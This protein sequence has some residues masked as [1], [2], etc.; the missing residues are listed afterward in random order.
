MK[1]KQI[2]LTGIL[3]IALGGLIL[4][5]CK[6]DSTA[7][8]SDWTAAQD[9]ANATSTSNDAQT[10]AN[11]AVQS[12]GHSP[13]NFSTYYNATVTWARDTGAGD[14]IYIVF[15]S[16]PTICGDYKYRE[17]EIIVYWP[18]GSANNVWAAYS[19]SAVNVTEEFRGYAV[20]TASNNMNTISGTRTWTN[21]GQNQG[22]YENWNFNANLT[23]TYSNGQKATWSSIRNNV[24]TKVG[25]TWYYAVSGNAT[26]TSRNGVIYTLNIA[27]PLYIT[28]APWWAGGCAWIE[29][30]TLNINRQ[31]NNNTLSVNFGNVG[32]CDAT[33]VATINGNNYTFSMW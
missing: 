22:G 33:A 29:S 12:A 13:I 4:T 15:P 3:G 11:T 31:G 23:L 6:K 21:E 25:G 14:T 9:D 27:S 18:K 26:G 2:L 10:M 7:A 16:T 24:L 32:T 20:G 19:D 28:A 30:G 8:D 5:G 1:T 17:G